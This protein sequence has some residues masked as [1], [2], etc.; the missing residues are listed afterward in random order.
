MRHLSYRDTSLLI[1]SSYQKAAWPNVHKFWYQRVHCLNL[2]HSQRGKVCCTNCTRQLSTLYWT[3]DMTHQLKWNNCAGCMRKRS[4]LSRCLT[5]LFQFSTCF[6]Q[7][8]AHHQ[9]NESSFPTCTRNGHRHSDIYQRLYWYNWF[10]WW[11]ARGC[12]KHVENWNKYI[13]KNCASSWL[14][15]KKWSTVIRP[16]ASHDFSTS[17]FCFSRLHSEA[18]PALRPTQSSVQWIPAACRR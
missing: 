15:T 5:Y 14:F 12:L 17:R 10:S 9:E 16:S 7:P 11:W 4:L 6:E 8:R 18:R 2:S 1:P 13:E 3:H